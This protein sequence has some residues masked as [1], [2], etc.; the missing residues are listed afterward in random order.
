MYESEIERERER[1]RAIVCV[2]MCVLARVSPGT[3]R[4]AILPDRDRRQDFE[5]FFSG[6][7]NKKQKKKEKAGKERLLY[8]EERWELEGSNEALVFRRKTR[9]TVTVAHKLGQGCPRVEE[10]CYEL[11][12][13]FASLSLF[14]S[15]AEA[16]R[17]P[18]EPVQA[19]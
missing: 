19:N 11:L 7:M 17:L 18:L 3:E 13:P 8:K 9:D 14:L 10:P 15:L 12:C 5:W 1:M 6:S 4:T 16:V 2:C